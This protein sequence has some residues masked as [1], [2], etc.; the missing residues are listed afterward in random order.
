M[1]SQTR[2]IHNQMN[3]ALIL[4][5]LIPFFTCL[6]P[7]GITILIVLRTNINGFGAILSLTFSWIP[8][9]NSATTIFIVKSYRKIVIKYLKHWICNTRKVGIQAQS[10]S[11]KIT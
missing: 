4:Q 8:L 9:A 7:V 6:L 3:K 10:Y 2:D 11:V 5:A 1:S